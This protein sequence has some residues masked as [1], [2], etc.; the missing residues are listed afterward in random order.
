MGLAAAAV[1]SEVVITVTNSKGALISPDHLL[2]VP[3]SRAVPVALWGQS[4]SPAL[5]GQ[6]VIEGA[7]CGFDIHGVEPVPGQ[8]AFIDCKKLEFE[9]ETAPSPDWQWTSAPASEATAAEQQLNAP[10]KETARREY[11]RTHLETVQAQRSELLRQLG[12]TTPVFPDQSLAQAF[13]IAPQLA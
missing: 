13:V 6:R 3:T 4:V 12:I 5:N 11:L 9:L 7:V 2:V 1:T 10:E 8:S